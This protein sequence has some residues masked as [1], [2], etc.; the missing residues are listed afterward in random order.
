[1]MSSTQELIIVC[2]DIYMCRILEI[3][4]VKY[5]H[6]FRRLACNLEILTMQKTLVPLLSM[7]TRW[8]SSKIYLR[9][10]PIL[11]NFVPQEFP[12]IRYY[13]KVVL[14]SVKF[15]KSLP[16]ISYQSLLNSTTVLFDILYI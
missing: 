15:C 11:E 7:V 9:K 16:M 2:I 14:W 12:N 13:Y 3:F 10:G 6:Y 4:E 5:F 8:P 1:M